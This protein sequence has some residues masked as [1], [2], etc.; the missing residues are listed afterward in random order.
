MGVGQPTPQVHARLASIVSQLSRPHG[1]LGPYASLFVAPRKAEWHVTVRYDNRW[2]RALRMATRRP[3]PDRPFRAPELVI[4]L[5]PTERSDVYSLGPLARMLWTGRAAPAPKVVLPPTPRGLFVRQRWIPPDADGSPHPALPIGF[6]DWCARCT[7]R[8]PDER[9]ATPRDALAALVA[10]PPTEPPDLVPVRTWAARL[11]AAGAV[12]PLAARVDPDRLEVVIGPVRWRLSEHFMGGPEAPLFDD[13]VAVARLLREHPT[14]SSHDDATLRAA[15]EEV[16]GRSPAPAAVALE[17]ED[18]VA[19]D[20]FWGRPNVID[21]GYGV[22][23]FAR[24]ARSSLPAD[25][26]ALAS[27]VRLLAS[28][29][30]DRGDRPRPPCRFCGIEPVEPMMFGDHCGPCAERWREV[31]W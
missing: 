15:I 26:E 16:L 12:G 13:V 25:H 8:R 9:F 7:A 31:V 10:L 24:I 18:L 14:T 11:E 23:V 20:V 5:F 28:A 4:G 6:E 22:L 3:D 27:L 30:F 2:T 1:A 19:Q 29:R 21:Q 17:G